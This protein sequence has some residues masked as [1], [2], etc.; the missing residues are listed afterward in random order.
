[1]HPL[2]KFLRLA[3]ADKVLLSLSFLTVTAVR[4]GLSLISFRVLSRYLERK[5]VSTSVDIDEARRIVWAVETSSR[6]VPGATCLV[7]AFAAQNLLARAG[8]QSQIRVG[9]ADS[10]GKFTAHA[11][12]TCDG[13]VV[14]GGSA[15]ELR[16]YTVLVDLGIGPS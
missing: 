1:M 11:W 4:I 14:M 6:V 7:R 13:R 10:S 12:L 9:V 8:Y 3:T 15:Q 5:V 16:R 2:V